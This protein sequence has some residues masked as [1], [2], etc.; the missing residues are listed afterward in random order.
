M[1]LEAP[2]EQL[3]RMLVELCKK[4]K[5][6]LDKGGFMTMSSKITG[7]SHRYFRD[8]MHGKMV[9]AKKRGDA[10]INLSLEKLN[11]ISRYLGYDSFV[12][13]QDSFKLNPYLAYFEGSYYSFI[14]KNSRSKEVIQSPVKIEK[15]GPG[16]RLT[17]KGED[18]E[19]EGDIELKEGCITCLI[20]SV[21][22]SFYHVYKVGKT[23]KPK[24]IQGIFSGV[25]SALDPIGGRCVLVRQES[26]FETLA[27][28]KIVLNKV[29]VAE[30]SY[31]Q[32]LWRYF[33]KNQEN[34][35]KI[36]TPVG[37]DLDDLMM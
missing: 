34:N 19:F 27:N 33:K 36:K 2:I 22:E 1:N 32:P 35:L 15:K 14:R 23:V 4:L 18:R 13:F 37:F 29:P 12:A 30:N 21:D 31:H 26:D 20:K 7:V 8:N 16:M 10:F 11:E 17:L 6:D 28:S 3:Q 24:V 5:V 25:S 9:A